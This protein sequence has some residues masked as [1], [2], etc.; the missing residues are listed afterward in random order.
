MIAVSVED[1]RSFSYVSHEDRIERRPVKVMPADHDSV[2]VIE[3]LN[4]G[5]VVALEPKLVLPDTSR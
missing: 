2:E 3:G 4:E 5:E 1:G